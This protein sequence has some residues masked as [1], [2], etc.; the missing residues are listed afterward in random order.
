MQ[1]KPLF[2]LVAFAVLIISIS[3]YISYSSSKVPIEITKENAEE[4]PEYKISPEEAAF[5]ASVEHKKQQLI[6]P[7][8][9]S[10][11]HSYANG[12]IKGS[13]KMKEFSAT[14]KTSNGYRTI[15]S[16][17]D[18][19]KD[20]IY[21][22]SYA[23]HIYRIDYDI[24]NPSNTQWTSINNSHTFMTESRKEWFDILNYNDGSA[25]QSRMLRSYRN[26]I[27]YSDDEGRN[28]Y[29]SK[30]VNFQVTDNNGC[31]AGSS[32]GDRAIVLA[33]IDGSSKVAISYDGINYTIS[34]L[35]I[36][37][38][39][40]A[41]ALLKPLHSDN[42]YVIARNKS[43][44][45]ST[46][47]RMLPSNSNF[48]E[49]Y[50]AN[51]PIS[52]VTR[53]L[54]T[55]VDGTFHFYYINGNDIFYSNNEGQ[56]WNQ[57]EAVNFSNT[58]GNCNVRTIHPDQPNIL[59]RGYLDTYMS[60]DQGANFQDWGHHLGW[61]TH[62]MRM[63]ELQDGSYMH[64][65]GNDFGA[66]IS[67]TPEDRDSYVQINHTSPTQMAYDM[68]VS[69]NFNTAFTALQDRGTRNFDNTDNPYTGE[70]R[71]TDGLRVTL[72]NQE[73]SVWT[74]MYFGTIY[75]QAN[76]GYSDGEKA[77]LRF[78]D[79][80]EAG[81]MVASP[82]PTEDAV[83]IANNKARLQKMTYHSDTKSL[84]LENISID[85]NALSGQNV[86]SF[87]YSPLNKNIWYVMVNNG[88]FFYSTDGGKS[89]Q[90]SLN[91]LAKGND[92]FYN[93]TRNQ[94]IIKGSKLDEEKVY[95]AGV[96]NA[97][98]ISNNNGRL[99]TNHAN[100]LNVY[101]IRD[102]DISDDEKFI[103]AA[104]AHAGAWV[105]SVD[106]N[107][108]YRMDGP[109]VPYV[110]FTG[111]NY[112]ASKGMVQFSTFGSGVLDFTFETP[113]GTPEA[114]K[115]LNAKAL[116]A[117][118]IALNWEATT[119][120]I[121]GYKILRTEDLI[122]FKEV[123]DIGKQ[124]T[125]YTDTMLYPTTQYYY[126]VV[127]YK[128]DNE[129]LPS[130]LA[131][132]TTPEITAL[133]TSKWKLIKV[134][135]RKLGSFGESAFDEDKTTQWTSTDTADYPHEIQIDLGQAENIQAFNY[136]GARG[137]VASSYE[138]YISNDTNNWGTPII[139]GTWES[140]RES[141]QIIDF[142]RTKGQYVRFR[143]L[144]GFRDTKKLSIVELE[145]WPDFDSRLDPP[146]DLSYSPISS[147][148][149]KLQWTNVSATAQGYIIERKVGSEYVEIGRTDNAYSN[150][151]YDR[152]VEPY[153]HCSYRIRA[154]R[155]DNTSE[156]S[157]VLEAVSM[158]TGL[159]D[160]SNWDVIYYDSRQ[161]AHN[162]E[163]A[164]DDNINTY[165]I[166]QLNPSITDLPHEIQI[167]M[168]AQHNLVAFSYVPRVDT[169][170]DG[171]I[172]DFE[173]YV[174]NNKNDWGSPVSQGQWT[175]SKRYN[176]GFTTKTG[177]YIRI[178]AK[179]E[180]KGQS[181][182]SI[183]ELMVWTQY[184]GTTP[185]KD[186]EQ[187]SLNIYPQPFKNSFSFTLTNSEQYHSAELISLN[188]RVLQRTA[189][190]G[191][192]T[193]IDITAKLKNGAYILRIT[194]DNNIITRKVIYQ[195]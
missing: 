99:F 59:Y 165:W 83:I 140:T 183:A 160:R 39:S 48:E 156:A 145:L 128:N 20:I 131:E 79:D 17:Y 23:G 86:S 55:Y 103:F 40:Y 70:I 31:I 164:F 35:S 172:Q 192:T 45:K 29:S 41:T 80:W 13:W 133:S 92:Q 74:W 154:F 7:K 147:T 69:N 184:D 104:C 95:A 62:H 67:K 58:K 50:T 36:N 141:A 101:R 124:N 54:G 155:N 9:A 82:D 158:S 105:F 30:G 182:S 78:A 42:V 108:W 77:G 12:K 139:K 1:N 135:S 38:V 97:F 188:G 8:S 179:S 21:V 159:V 49:L 117:S 16:A 126:R 120:E 61:D 89:F 96:A 57:I 22:V 191:P 148:N 175:E 109:E 4:R 3:Y 189:I 152:T 121:D 11:V 134:S 167:D 151:F 27:Q 185:L 137:G 177:R 85:F 63:L 44:A 169:I 47:Y 2:K 129:S 157:E 170:K 34:N 52:Y 178:V 24:N 176:M 87:G 73:K 161:F 115:N 10:T 153:M 110:D 195:N 171:S 51:T 56:S 168:K 194:G 32:S 88:L 107:Q 15:Y 33:Q 81:S 84:S 64:L 26:R 180:L 118:M 149:I 163:K 132:T 116:S 93:Y 127:A 94:Q 102:F 122:T 166:S 119:S 14:G 187:V 138:L 37:N 75:H 91:R 190:T 106:D 173:F 111:V 113:E 143:A 76:H 123:A 142:N 112:T 162:P 136:L 18:K 19:A 144:S 60:S 193:T 150:Y 125:E 114:P 72:A 130:T 186:V 66:Y 5:N 53:L 174:S 28:W 46:I 6:R 25:I 98:Y 146:V 68:D 90:K 181:M 43:T 100:G 65:I 71:S